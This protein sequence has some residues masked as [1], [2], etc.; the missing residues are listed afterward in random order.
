[1]SDS[2]PMESRTGLIGSLLS[3]AES[4]G[5]YAV[6]RFEERRGRSVAVEGEKV[7]AVESIFAGGLGV[8]V[9]TDT[10]HNGFAAVDD[11]G[12][13]R[14][15]AALERAM[16]AAR[17]AEEAGL[18]AMPGILRAE[19]TVGRHVPDVPYA[20]DHLTVGEMREATV[21]FARLALEAAGDLAVRTGFGLSR[22]DWRIARSDGTDV[23]FS[24]PRSH[25][26]V[27][28][29]ARR[30]G[31]AVRT[32]ASVPATSYETILDEEPRGKLVARTTR[33]AA[34]ARDLLDAPS[35]PA[36][37]VPLLIDFA[38]AKG[39][40]HEAFG[41]AAET[42]GLTSS[43]LGDGG[44]FRTGEMF[45]GEN[46]TII[47][48]SFE[49]DNAFQPFSGNG[50]PRRRAVILDH[51]VLKEALA[52]VHTADRAG[53]PVTG[54]GRL[55]GFG[56]PPLPRMT[57]IR[58]EV[59]DPFPVPGGKDFYDWTPEEVRDLLV[60]AGDLPDG[61]KV[62]FLSG[63]RGGQVNPALG[64]FVFN[65]TAMYEL[66]RDSVTLYKPGIF[67][68]RIEAALH[69]IERGYGPLRLD[70]AGTC[71]KAGQGVPSSGGSHH[72]LL[73]SEN[74]DIRIGG[75]S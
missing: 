34:L 72:F 46:V 15:H 21:A 63:Y 19:K 32:N 30:D 49:A 47:D 27:V 61:R 65:S 57:N 41:H 56:V 31:Q 28:V 68:G 62:L 70:A 35:Y 4:E 29:T 45:G 10:G 11:P 54:A 59:D 24:I 58:L 9:F 42:D 36:G 69:S 22:S 14:S 67:S 8:Q 52:D 66:T 64:D 26:G 7:D 44:R 37:T 39:L 20:F 6:L 33:A 53:T 51:G 55:S 5:L 73:M 75:R 16:A 40:A 43:I 50:V 2:L 60:T 13:D 71:G 38:L 3:R 1:M 12:E 25:A 48:E 74:D 23:T 17:A 18:S